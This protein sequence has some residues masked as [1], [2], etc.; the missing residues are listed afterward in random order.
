MRRELSGLIAACAL[1]AAPALAQG[2]GKQDSVK[3]APKMA[4]KADTAKPGTKVPPKADQT[5][6]APAKS[7]AKADQ[8]KQPA[9]NPQTKAPQTQQKAPEQTKQAAPPPASPP[10]AKPDTGKGA[11]LSQSG[12]KNQMT[13]MR[14]IFTYEPAG[15][16]DPMASLVNTPTLRPLLSEIE[17]IGILYDEDGRRSEAVMRSLDKKKTYRVRVGQMLGRMTVA[18]ITR[19]EVV[20]T[21]DEYGF[22]RQVSLP[23]KPDTSIARTP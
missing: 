13:I 11:A 15:R 8:G 17:C 12:G 2:G 18:Q 19:R 6:Q 7:T 4:A 5:K 1:L 3:P 23:V 10:A 21:I 14:E 22:S 20:F 9:A 16:R